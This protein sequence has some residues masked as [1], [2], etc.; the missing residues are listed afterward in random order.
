VLDKHRFG[1]DRTGAARIG[2]RLSQPD[3]EEDGEMA[4]TQPSKIA[5]GAR[6]AN[7]L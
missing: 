5:T 6:N 2:E 3:A 4:H 7:E 1:H